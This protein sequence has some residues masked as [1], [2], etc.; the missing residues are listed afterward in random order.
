MWYNVQSIL[1]TSIINSYIQDEILSESSNYW[2]EK[3]DSKG[4][5]EISTGRRNG[6]RIG[7]SD[8]NRFLRTGI[9]TC[10]WHQTDRIS[11]G[12]WEVRQ[13]RTAETQPTNY[14][15][16]WLRARSLGWALKRDEVCHRELPEAKQKG[17]GY[18]MQNR[19]LT[20]SEKS[21]SVCYA[22]KSV[23]YAVFISRIHYALVLGSVQ[24]ACAVKARGILFPQP[25]QAAADKTPRENAVCS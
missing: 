17:N 23:P 1:K 16:C 10:E 12:V 21:L 13:K 25:H 20:A 18:S 15:L 9:C 6:N 5:G 11:A 2:F 7:R 24:T 3:L 19:Y 22:K 14:R 8:G 4:F